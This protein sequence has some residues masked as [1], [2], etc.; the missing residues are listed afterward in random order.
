M[1]ARAR[2]A[3]QHR[4]RSMAQLSNARTTT[5]TLETTSQSTKRTTDGQV[6]RIDCHTLAYSIDEVLKATD[7]VLQLT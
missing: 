1:L 6:D 3:G 5:A 4:D 7:E 2:T